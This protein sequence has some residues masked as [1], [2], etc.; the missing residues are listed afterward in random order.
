[1]GKLRSISLTTICKWAT[2][3][4][5]WLYWQISQV[6]SFFLL[7]LSLLSKV[8]RSDRTERRPITVPSSPHL[9]NAFW[10]ESECYSAITTI[11]GEM[12]SDR[13]QSLLSLLQLSPITEGR[14]EEG[15]PESWQCINLSVWRSTEVKRLRD[16]V[17]H[18]SILTTLSIAHVYDKGRADR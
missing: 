1:M 17:T 8:P 18:R 14:A 2:S 3:N 10:M 11:T 7:S 16:P 5:L 13:G 6:V 4:L 9:A 15:A 12:K